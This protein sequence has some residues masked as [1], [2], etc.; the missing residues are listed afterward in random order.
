MLL[1]AGNREILRGNSLVAFRWLTFGNR[2]AMEAEPSNNFPSTIW[3]EVTQAAGIS[4]AS[5]AA[6]ESLLKQYSLPLEVHLSLRFGVTK[7][8]AADWLQSF[9]LQRVLLGN[10]LN[11]AS[12]NRGK[13]RTFLLNALDN[14]VVSEL[15]RQATLRRSPT[16]GTIPLD[17]IAEPFGSGHGSNGEIAAE[18]AREVLAKTLERM[19]AECGAKGCMGRWGIFKARLLD[20]ELEGTKAP[21]YEELVTRFGFRSPAE[22]ANALIT[23]KRQFDRLLHDV[24]ADY[25]GGPA[26]VEEEIRELKRALSGDC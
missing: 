22:T 24:I 8:Q 19:Q 5:V 15:R 11:R 1:Y 14:F 13:F 3:T 20:P 18:W 21:A 23:A 26:E 16:G 6:L 4:D 12:K 9:I 7:D 2:K 10:M 17:E 25:A